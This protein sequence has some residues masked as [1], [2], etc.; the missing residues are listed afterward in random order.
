MSL[1]EPSVTLLPVQSTPSEVK[2][3]VGPPV[4]NTTKA[5]L[6][7]TTNEIK[8]STPPSVVVAAD[9]PKTP[10]LVT[11]GAST[12]EHVDVAEPKTEVEVEA[13]TETLLDDTTTTPEVSEPKSTTDPELI[14]GPADIPETAP[15]P[16]GEE[17]QRLQ[18]TSVSAADSTP[19]EPAKESTLD[20][21]EDDSWRGS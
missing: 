6:P 9:A 12:H 15:A 21:I 7:E 3:E 20:K 16:T 14:V 2:P 5:T 17:K 18:V 8:L 1:D 10:E 19:S 4:E 13:E 11:E